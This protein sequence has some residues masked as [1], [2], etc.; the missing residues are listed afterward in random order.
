MAI[1][2]DYQKKYIKVFK[3]FIIFSW[4]LCNDRAYSSMCFGFQKIQWFEKKGCWN[5]KLVRFVKSVLPQLMGWKLFLKKLAII[6]NTFFLLS[7]LRLPSIFCPKNLI[8]NGLY[9][10]RWQPGLDILRT[11]IYAAQQ[12]LTPQMRLVTPFTFENVSTFSLD[13]HLR[14]GFVVSLFW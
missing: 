9:K 8:L 12:F 13:P 11:G 6:W 3:N 5:F 2:Y 4:V 10:K 1:S 7:C 14:I